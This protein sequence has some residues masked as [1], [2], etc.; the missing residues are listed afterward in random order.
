MKKVY[1][2]VGMAGSGKSEAVT[3]LV[4]KLGWPKVYMAAPTFD[5]LKKKGLPINYQ[6]E[7]IA[8]ETIREQFGANA[9]AKLALKKTVKLLKKNKGVIVESLYSWTEYKIFKR[10]FGDNFQVIAVHA[11][12]AIRFQ[13][14]KSRRNERPMK[15]YAEFQVRDYS[16][17]EKVEKGGPIVMAD[18]FILNEGN[19]RALHKKLAALI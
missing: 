18:Y 13:R 10:K 2:V 4:N 3:Y 19:L 8:R 14:L 15:N 6:N 7:K 1:A 17:I 11:T 12:P 9:Y 5:W 16:E